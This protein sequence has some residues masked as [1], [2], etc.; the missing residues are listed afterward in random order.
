[1]EVATLLGLFLGIGGILFGNFIEGGRTAAL[2]QEAAAII[3]LSGTFGA[4][5]VS[6]KFEDVKIALRLA[7]QAFMKSNF[8]RGP[9]LGEIV[10]CARIA[11]KETA[12]AI[13]PRLPQIEDEFLR[14][15]MR[16]VV[17]GVDA[18]VMSEV[19][20]TRMHSEEEKLMAGAK[21]WADAGGFAPTIGIIGAVL[22]LIQVMSN[23]SDTSKLGAGIA[24]AFVATIY[25][26]GFAN[27]IFLPLS[28][29]IKKIVS[30]SMKAREMALQGGLGIRA[31]L[32]PGVL[33]LK[34]KAYLETED[35]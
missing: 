16:T 21:V 3:V 32:S 18:G 17:D 29:K 24:V 5:L 20:H 14:D 19:F 34:L 33:E 9:L 15:V 25:G 6:S 22:G 11:R 1:M 23:L 8:H 10:E 27:L 2:V 4:V 35:E 12:L 30:D 28:N 31:G 7:K 26:V 13:E